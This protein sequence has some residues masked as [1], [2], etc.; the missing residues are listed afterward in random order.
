MAVTYGSASLGAT[1]GY[2]QQTRDYVCVLSRMHPEIPAKM[3]GVSYEYVSSLHHSREEVARDLVC[4][5]ALRIDRL[6]G[7]LKASSESSIFLSKV[8]I[9]L[10]RSSS[11]TFIHSKPLLFCF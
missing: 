3:L 7:S 8:D 6:K 10:H 2:V 11:N 5:T 4:G 1:P 9:I